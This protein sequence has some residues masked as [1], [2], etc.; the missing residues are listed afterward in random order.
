M[1]EEHN[2]GE[3]WAT[4]LNEMFWDLSDNFGMSSDLFD[5]SRKEGN[6]VA[7]QLMIGALMIQPCN[8]TFIQAR[9][10]IIQTEF[11]YYNGEHVSILWKSFARRGLG[12]NAVD[13]FVDDYT[14]PV[15]YDDNS[16]SIT[17]LGN[18]TNSTSGIL[19]RGQYIRVYYDL[20]RISRCEIIKICFFINNNTPKCCRVEDEEGKGYVETAF[21]LSEA[22]ILNIYIR[23]RKNLQK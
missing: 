17:F 1:N 7:I 12:A 14:I 22:G 5:S 15:E 3:I 8:P 23:V 10:A 4:M 13:D 19:K 16:A 21:Y 2:L 11:N 20:T 6:I 18:Y 9:D